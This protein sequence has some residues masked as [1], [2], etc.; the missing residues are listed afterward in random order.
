MKLEQSFEVA[1]PPG[2]V[3]SALSDVRGVAAC[4]PGAEV[5]EVGADGQLK[6]H[7]NVRLGPI[8]AAFAGE[9]R[10]EMDDAHM[11]GRMVGGG[12]DRQSRSQCRGSVDFRLS[13][14]GAGTRVDLAVDYT[15]TG[16]LAQFGRGGLVA[17]LAV[18][19]T[20]DFARSLEARLN[21]ASP[22]A[23]PPQALA[24]G[25]LLWRVLRARIGAFFRRLFG[26][27]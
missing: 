26:G 14:A 22:A 24:A 2:R 11:Q 7:I 9:G 12:Q 4:L 5:T 20:A 25:A 17:D 8:A 18:R 1:H 15:L 27:G 10:L 21:Q 6:G 13:P 3:W 19:L 23:E 16:S